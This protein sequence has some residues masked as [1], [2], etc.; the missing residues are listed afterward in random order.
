[1]G[2]KRQLCGETVTNVYRH[3]RLVGAGDQADSLQPPL[4]ERVQE[5]LELRQEQLIILFV[6]FLP[7]CRSV[8]NLLSSQKELR[9]L[10][11][12]AYLDLKMT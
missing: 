2:E 1:V 9:N 12:L 5:F 11:W 4:S 6:M 10:G 3:F 7:I 8:L